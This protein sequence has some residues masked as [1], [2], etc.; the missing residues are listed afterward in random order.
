MRM[1]FLDIFSSHIGRGLQFVQHLT[2]THETLPSFPYGIPSEALNS[3]IVHFKALKHL[4]IHDDNDA[5][6]YDDLRAAAFAIYLA[7]TAKCLVYERQKP[8]ILVQLSL[9]EGPRKPQPFFRSNCQKM[10]KKMLEK[11]PDNHFHGQLSTITIYIKYTA[12]EVYGFLASEIIDG[13]G[14]IFAGQN[15]EQVASLCELQW[16][17]RV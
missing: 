13:W 8:R 17:R 10:I 4:Y 14:F 6:E 5:Y 9:Q 12:N 7:S 1:A 11:Q 16:S 15:A 2:L 3:I